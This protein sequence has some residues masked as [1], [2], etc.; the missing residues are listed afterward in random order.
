MFAKLFGKILSDRIIRWN[1]AIVMVCDYFFGAFLEVK[2]PIVYIGDTTFRLFKENMKIATVKFEKIADS[3]EQRMIDNADSIIFLSDWAKESA[4]KDYECL[5]S[6]IH[7]V[8]FG[9]NSPTPIQYRTEIESDICNWVFIG[10]EWKR[11]GG[12]KV[13]DTYH[14]LIQN[15]FKCK[16]TIIGSTPG[17][18][19][20]S[21]DNLIIIP[22]L[23]KSKKEDLDKLDGI[24]KNSHFLF[25]PTNFEPFGIVFCEASAYGVPSITAQCRRRKPAR[26]RRKRRISFAPERHSRGLCRE[27]KIGVQR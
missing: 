5:E 7:I 26:K 25:L 18:E 9:A 15:G 11:K 23:D 27:N 20:E 24:L 17:Y 2:I 14:S 1:Y 22:H 16:L 19:L 4:L 10:K 3:I 21:D 6:K 13:I 12:D 8:E